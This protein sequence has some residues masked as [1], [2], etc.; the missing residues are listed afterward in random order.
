MFYLYT[1]FCN[2]ASSKGNKSMKLYSDEEL[3]LILDQD[4]FHK[5]SEAAE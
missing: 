5:I 2:F 3:A 4:I 1:F